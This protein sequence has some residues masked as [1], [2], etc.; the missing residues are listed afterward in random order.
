M[1]ILSKIISYI[2]T[3]LLI[4]CVII[5]IF[6]N[7]LHL[8]VLSKNA[9]LKNLNSIYYYDK[10]YAHI[11]S[12]FENY[13]QQSGLSEDVITDLFTKDDLIADTNAIIKDIYAGNKITIDDSK[14]KNSLRE[15]IDASLEG[16]ISTSATTKAINQFIEKISSAYKESLV[17]SEEIFNEI[18]KIIAKTN[19]L[20]PKAQLI[21]LV[22]V[23]I[24]LSFIIIFNLKNL[25][26]VFN[27]LGI[28][29]LAIG[30]IFIFIKIFVNFNLTI[31]NLQI[32]NIAISSLISS[33]IYS[34]LDT[35][36]TL[37]IVT[38]VVGLLFTIL[39]HL[40]K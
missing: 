10:L 30:F 17:P 24:L 5:F 12:E 19:D 25:K 15:K 18:S 11:N 21:L 29:S 34:T 2:A 37:G 14:I 33:I 8:N 31:S 27:Y 16:R 22:L 40:K 7:I 36:F 35:I 9:I 13:I 26:S 3:F 20:L 6:S 4:I 39:A 32:F 38:C 23:I 28:T 1:K